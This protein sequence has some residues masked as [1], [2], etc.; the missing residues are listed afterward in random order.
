MDLA[1]FVLMLRA[2][3]RKS[4]VARLQLGDVNWLKS[5]V[6][7]RKSKNFKERNVPLNDET[8]IAL[9]DWLKVRGPRADLPATLFVARQAPLNESYFGQRL[10][11]HC[12]RRIKVHIAPHQLRHTCATLLLNNGMPIE[13]VQQ[14]LGHSKIESTLTYTRVYPHLLAAD[15]ARAMVNI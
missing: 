12:F 14:V 1:W 7:V 4:E 5:L 15:F 3:L 10:R 13:A 6:F 8:K 2:G 9:R 11:L